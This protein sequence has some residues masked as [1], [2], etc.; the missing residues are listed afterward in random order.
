MLSLLFELFLALKE[1]GPRAE[2][3]VRDWDDSV[4]WG[5]LS[6]SVLSQQKCG[7]PLIPG[8]E[9]QNVL[10]SSEVTHGS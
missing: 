10:Y 6:L 7:M 9:G 1:V 4:S 8:N 2:S 5:P 3:E